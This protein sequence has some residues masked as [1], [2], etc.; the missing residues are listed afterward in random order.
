[1]T[2]RTHIIRI[3]N[4]RGIRI[5]EAML[6]QLGEGDEVELVAEQDRLVIRPASHPREGWDEQFRAMAARGDDRLLDEPVAT[7]WDGTDWAW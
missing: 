7:D 3:G 4:E 1:M 5:P 2:L 6:E